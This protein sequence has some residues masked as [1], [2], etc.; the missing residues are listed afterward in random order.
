[1]IKTADLIF[2]DKLPN[3]TLTHKEGYDFLQKID[4]DQKRKDKAF[5][6]TDSTNK[7]QD[8]EQVQQFRLNM[9]YLNTVMAK[10]EEGEDE[11]N[12]RHYDEL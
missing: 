7:T 2:I 1:M 12:N 4:D 11:S 3:K 8:N 6:E 5:E 9:N 10:A